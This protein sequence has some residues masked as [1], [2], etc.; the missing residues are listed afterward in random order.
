M[1]LCAHLSVA[2]VGC[3][4]SSRTEFDG[5]RLHG[6]AVEV[7]VFMALC[8]PVSPSCWSIALQLCC[9]QGEGFFPGV[10]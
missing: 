8:Y 3:T 7:T 9:G 2:L 4:D 1:S 10:F 5:T 6:T